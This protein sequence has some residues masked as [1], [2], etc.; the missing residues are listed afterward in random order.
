MSGLRV[1]HA[2]DGAHV[3]LVLDRPKGNIVTAELE[4]ACFGSFPG[5]WRI[6]SGS[7][8]IG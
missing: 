4:P 7:T 1:E 3:R 2:R 6:S 8:S 5:C